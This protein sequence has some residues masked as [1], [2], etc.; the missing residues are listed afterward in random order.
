MKSLRIGM[1]ET[2]VIYVHLE[3]EKAQVETCT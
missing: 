2:F 1:K 3:M